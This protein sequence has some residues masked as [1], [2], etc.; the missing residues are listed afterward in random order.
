MQE[1]GAVGGERRREGQALRVGGVGKGK[2]NASGGSKW[3]VRTVKGE[4]P[5]PH[6]LVQQGRGGAGTWWEAAAGKARQDPRCMSGNPLSPLS[7][8][9]P[10]PSF[11][12][13]R[14]P[15]LLN[16]LPCR[17]PHPPL[18]TVCPRRQPLLPRTQCPLPPGLLF[19]SAA[20]QDIGGLDIQKQEIREAVE[21]PLTQGD[22]YAQIGIDPPRG[23]LLWGPPGTGEQ[24]CVSGGGGGEGVWEG[25]AERGGG[26]GRWG[27]E[28]AARRPPPLG[29]AHVAQA[30]LLPLLWQLVCERHDRGCR[31][32]AVA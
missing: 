11:T 23:V 21:L 2:G 19:F 24:L 16:T 3:V 14:L 6:L 29:A 25:C 31:N 10:V 20:P 15:L 17:T 22:L 1:G 5:S 4:Q 32:I 30:W 13:T 26:L 12:R 28:G 8:P 7:M 27:T 9:N 18:T